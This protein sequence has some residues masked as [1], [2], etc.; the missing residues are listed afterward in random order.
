MLSIMISI[1]MPIKISIVIPIMIS[2]GISIMISMTSSMGIESEVELI[3]MLT[4]YH[5]LGYIVYYGDRVG[6]Q[7]PLMDFVILNPQWLINVFKQVITIPDPAKIVRYIIFLIKTL[8]KDSHSHRPVICPKFI[9]YFV[10][11]VQIPSRLDTNGMVLFC[12][13]TFIDQFTSCHAI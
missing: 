10:G 4:F 5:D 2:I 7:S 13:S 8:L 3:T 6:N 12:C 9:L 1:M 11:D